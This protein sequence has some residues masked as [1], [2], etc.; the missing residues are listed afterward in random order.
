[1]FVHTLARSSSSPIVPWLMPMPRLAEL[2]AHCA[3]LEEGRASCRRQ[4]GHVGR[5]ADVAQKALDARGAQDER[6][7]LHAGRWLLGFFVSVGRVARVLER[8][9]RNDA[10]A[11]LVRRRQRTGEARDVLIEIERERAIAERS[12]QLAA[13]E[14]VRRELDAILSNRR[15]QHILAE[16]LST[17]A[18]VCRD[19][20]C[21]VQGKSGLCD[22]ECP[23]DLDWQLGAGR[24]EAAHR[25]ARQGGQGRFALGEF[26]VDRLARAVAR[27]IGSSTR[28]ADAPALARRR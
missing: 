3:T 15:T 2:S 1:M 7:K 26:S 12:A 25:R 11:P 23:P 21:R 16:R 5:L 24:S 27:V 22:A 20:G 19:D 13:H 17:G 8:W 10:R 18:V 28:V 14:T 9:R 4:R 6:A